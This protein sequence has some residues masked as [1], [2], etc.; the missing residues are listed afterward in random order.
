MEHEHDD[1]E[2]CFQ[3][4]KRSQRNINRRTWRNELKDKIKVKELVWQPEDYDCTS[5][6]CGYNCSRCRMHSDDG[7][8]VEIEKE[9]DDPVWTPQN[10]TISPKPSVTSIIATQKPKPH[11]PNPDIKGHNFLE[12]N[13][14]LDTTPQFRR[15]VEPKD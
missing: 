8:W 5:S 15:V 1:E 6:F 13:K 14:I 9:I 11:K 10:N 3:T 4:M 12:R 7:K 2:E